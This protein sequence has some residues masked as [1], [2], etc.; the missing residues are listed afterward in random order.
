M[1]INSIDGLIGFIGLAVLEW[2]ALIFFFL[3]TDISVKLVFLGVIFYC[4][5]WN[6]LF[7]LKKNRAELESSDTFKLKAV[8]E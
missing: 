2:L 4:A 7:L 1:K 6:G 8:K 5:T 3:E